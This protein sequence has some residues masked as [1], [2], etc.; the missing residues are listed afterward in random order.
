M[1]DEPRPPDEGGDVGE[2]A[3]RE[4]FRPDEDSGTSILERIERLTGVRSRLLLAEEQD[5]HSP[6][7]KVATFEDDR[8]VAD[9]SRYHVVGEIARGGV[10]VVYKARDADLGRDVALKVLKSSPS[11]HSEVFD[12]F[13]EE[14][15]IGGQL[16]HP[17]IVP[18]YSL[19][20]QPDGRPFFAMKLIKGRT[21]AAALKERADPGAERR[22]FLRDFE[23]I[24]RTMAYA[25]ARGVI[26]RDLKPSNVML[27]GFGEVLVV[28]WGFGKVLGQRGPPRPEQERTIVTTVRSDHE[29]SASAAGSVMGT[30][31]YMPPEQALGHV[32]ELD[33]QTDVF[34]L[35]AIL[36][37]ILTGKPPYVGDPKDL[38]VMASQARLED[39]YRRLDDCGADPALR[40]LARRCLAPMRADRP[41]DAS[42]VAAEIGR[43]LSEAEERAHRAEVEAV[44]ERGRLR[45]AREQADASR[46]AK[47]LTFAAA[48]A[49]LLA[50]L[51][52]GGALFFRDAR[53]RARAAEARPAVERA[54]EEAARLSGEGRWSEAVAAARRAVSLSAEADE[55]TRE[56]AHDAVARAEAG[57]RAAEAAARQRA[58]EAALLARLEEIRM[59]RAELPLV[60]QFEQT[61]EAY[62][63]AFRDHGIDIAAT[64]PATAA[65]AILRRFPAIAGELAA[66]L[67]DQ[68]WLRARYSTGA[69]RDP[70]ALRQTAAAVD[71]DAWRGRLRTA[72][73]RRDLEALRA[74]ASEARERDLPP[75][76][77]DLLGQALGDA[78]DHEEA[79]RLLEGAALTHPGDLWLHFHLGQEALRTH[80]PLADR[81]TDHLTA[82]IALRPASAWAW[83]QRGLAHSAAGRHEEAIEDLED[84]VRREPE[85]WGRHYQLA[86]EYLEAGRY[87]EAM[88]A[89]EQAL[90]LAPEAA[91]VPC[92]NHRANLLRRQGDLDGAI[93]GYREA[94]RLGPG[95]AVLHRNL[96]RALSAGGRSEEA[97]AAFREALRLDP[98]DPETHHDLGA[99]A[100]GRGDVDGAVRHLAEA[101]RL[102]P[103]N[104]LYHLGLGQFL[105]AARRVEEAG[106]ELREALRLDPDFAPAHVSL[107]VLRLRLGRT[108]EALASL[109]CALRLAPEDPSVHANLA[110]V[111]A[112]LGR[113]AEAEREAREAL[114]RGAPDAMAVTAREALGRALVGQ[115]RQP[116]AAETLREAARLL[117]D[118]HDE[119]GMDLAK[120]WQSLASAFGKAGLVDEG[121]EACREALK[122]DGGDPGTQKVLGNLLLDA[123]RQEEAVA[124][125]R[126]ATDLDPEDATTL[127]ILGIALRALD[128]FDE[129]VEAIREAMRLAPGQAA[130]V[131]SLGSVLAAR[132]DLDEAT[133][134]LREATALDPKLTIGWVLLAEC[135]ARRGEYRQAE[136]IVRVARDL[137]P[138]RP[139]D[140]FRFPP[141]DPATLDDL[142][143][144][145][146]ALGEAAE[147]ASEHLAGRWTPEHVRETLALGFI[148]QDREHEDRP[149]AAARLYREIFT[150]EPAA[151]RGSTPAGANLANPVC[152]AARA[153]TG[154]GKDAA[155]LPEAERAAW[156]RT[157]LGWLRDL[158][159]LARQTAD[160][161][162]AE[163]AGRS[164]AGLLRDN[165][166][167][168]VRDEPGLAKLPPAERREWEA[169]WAEVRSRA[170]EAGGR[171]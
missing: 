51:A 82:A 154:E 160:G 3:L 56:R 19:G 164:L 47:R 155:G 79:V 149:V 111:L 100:F 110:Q 121:M 39:A 169:A 26:H 6:M 90:R 1:G 147:R 168:A 152:A 10:G 49:V 98:E 14:A 77:L 131:Y 17:G 35:G 104:K 116:E 106:R 72:A 95:F 75:R 165:D 25:H 114:D 142:E 93:A 132:G 36:T 141:V 129:A 89:G 159:A 40:N 138:S 112:T 117:A 108:V 167:R 66:A 16:Q 42:E 158:L 156:R 50:V 107:G 115:G 65:G 8:G 52:G 86:M 105:M 15:Q 67:D 27:G 113:H 7:L 128:R 13:V 34:A 63:A 94:I 103:R 32:E 135:L 76:T 57:L 80:P 5:D 127:S 31:A 123:G 101:V 59:R 55:P 96:G 130:H 69:S 91:A 38:L 99:S 41:A 68:A 122:L 45:R 146:G 9:D 139:G 161:P 150:K 137:G 118:R 163:I 153:G 24:C 73:A 21:L 78:G 44:R 97:L 140:G 60:R 119:P 81:A 74:L 85:Y 126:R 29:G 28:D 143:G 70:E 54:V 20:L 46:R 58:G 37:E 134:R 162:A 18:V 12:R 30:P 53:V 157:A 48:A 43:H 4:A 133:T 22:L 171:R 120:R 92:A 144:W 87:A 2:E 23:R 83:G 102:A 109:R 136:A 33:A 11:S 88:A 124:A 71:P 170:A 148:L 64:D 166:L 145:F 125:F 84:A 151:V 62:L 61:D